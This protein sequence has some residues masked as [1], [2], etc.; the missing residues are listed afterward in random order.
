MTDGLKGYLG[1]PIDHKKHSVCL[2]HGVRALKNHVRCNPGDAVAF[3]I[4]SKAGEVFTVEKEYRAKLD[5]LAISPQE[6]LDGRREAV[7]KILDEM[8]VLIDACRDCRLKDGFASA[9]GYL[10]SY[11]EHFYS[12]LDSVECTPDNNICELKAKPFAVGRGNWLF[13]QNVDG[14]DAT[15]FFYSLI[16]TA[17]DNGINPEKYLEHVLTYGPSARNEDFSSLLPWNADLSRTDRMIS[18]RKSAVGDSKRTEKYILT[19]FSR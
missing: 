7:T 1:G 5:S 10:R 4:L 6:F 18:A 17:K 3:R 13:A 12:F 11:R 16:E 19:G 15:C 8:F 2:V 9:I 14:I